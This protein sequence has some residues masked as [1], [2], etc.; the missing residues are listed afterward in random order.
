MTLIIHCSLS[1]ACFYRP[2]V[3]VCPRGL[4]GPGG[5]C[6][7]GGACFQE[8]CLL[9][10]VPAP[11]GVPAL[12]GCA[13]SGGV[14]GLGGAWWRPPRRLRLWAVRILLEC[15]LVRII[16]IYIWYHSL[17]CVRSIET[18]LK[19]CRMETSSYFH[20]RYV[21]SSLFYALKSYCVL[22]RELRNK[23]ILKTSTVPF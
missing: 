21:T 14:P 13:W 11:G 9:Q 15:I 1:C 17:P 8:E 20:M 16:A 6:S 7:R 4:P 5:T 23:K 12:G 10:G 19:L 22:S 3:C 2:Q 18:A